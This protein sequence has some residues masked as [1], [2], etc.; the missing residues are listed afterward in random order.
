MKLQTILRSGSLA[1]AAMLALLSAAPA[2]YAAPEL[3]EDE[4][5]IE[6][7]EQEKPE[8]YESGDYTYS[9]LVAAD[10]SGEQAACIEQYNGRETDLVIPAELDG[11][12]VVQLGKNAFVDADYL[13]SV[14]LPETLTSLGDYAFVNCQ[15]LVEYRVAAGNAVYESKDGVLYRGTVLER[16]PLGTVPT[17]IVIP[18]GVTGIGDVAF[19]CSSMLSSVTLPDSLTSIGI[20]AFS[21]CERLTSFTVP[22]GVTEIANFTFNSCGSLENITLPDTIERIGFAALAATGLK[23]FTIPASCKEI[24]EQAFAQTKL[25]EIMIPKTVESIGEKAFGYQLDDADELHMNT[26]FVIG[27]ELGTAAEQYAKIGEEGHSFQFVNIGAEE[28]P[29]EPDAEK[30]HI[31]RIIGI[32]VCALLLIG[33]LLFA[34]L[35]GKKKAKKT[36]DNAAAPASEDVPAEESEKTPAAEAVSDSASEADAESEEE[37]ADE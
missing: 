21:D 32:I 3:E 12:A 17:E 5:I 2:V 31:G 4:Y 15:K 6:T 9:K 11:L 18:E 20:A 22:D 28:D 37:S 10:D 29:E 36:D 8:T 35:S 25:A 14:T 23:T 34:L 16:Y 24:G 33:I 7:P 30:S 19:A 1:S 13:H 26:D 27:G